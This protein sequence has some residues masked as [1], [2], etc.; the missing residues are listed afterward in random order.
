MGLR[1]LTDWLEVF[2]GM[3][4]SLNSLIFFFSSICYSNND[5]DDDDDND[6]NQGSRK[7]FLAPRQISHGPLCYVN[8]IIENKIKI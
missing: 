3:V 8:L 5:N 7:K 6:D 2:D 4:G 1:F